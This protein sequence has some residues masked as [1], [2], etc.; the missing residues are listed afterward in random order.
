MEESLK[1]A[2]RQVQK[3]KGKQQ[4]S[5][6]PSS[7]KATKPKAPTTSDV[8]RQYVGFIQQGVEHTADGKALATEIDRRI[9]TPLIDTCR[10]GLERQRTGDFC[11]YFVDGAWT[12]VRPR[13]P[14]ETA[15]L[16]SDYHSWK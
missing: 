11:E 6:G 7:P 8:I 2:S 16:A 9:P 10:C 12:T 4:K 5:Q 15:D 3:R 14:V 1:G 13:C